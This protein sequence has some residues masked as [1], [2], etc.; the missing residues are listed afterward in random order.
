MPRPT[1]REV[2]TRWGRRLAAHNA[3]RPPSSGGECDKVLCLEETALADTTCHHTH[4]SVDQLEIDCEF[5]R[6]KQHI[7]G[8]ALI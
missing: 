7:C 5:L 8:V 3:L 1:R 4:V 6:R 2:E